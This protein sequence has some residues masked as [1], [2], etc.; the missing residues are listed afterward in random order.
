MFTDFLIKE[1]KNIP[2]GI[3]LQVLGQKIME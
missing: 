3:I 1:N 2:S